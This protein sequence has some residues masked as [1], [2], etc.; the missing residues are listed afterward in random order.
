[1]SK[2]KDDTV[3]E[4]KFIGKH[5]KPEPCIIALLRILTETKIEGVKVDYNGSG[6]S[7]SVDDIFIVKRVGTADDGED[8]WEE[9][10][11][12]LSEELKSAAE[13]TLY[14]IVQ[15]DFNNDGSGGSMVFFVD[16]KGKLNMKGTHQDYY[17][18]SEDTNYDQ[19]LAD[20]KDFL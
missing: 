1:M 4:H 7:G 3:D 2:K 8:D 9:T 11:T 14:H 13:D 5:K 19:V 17:T 10:K 20:S 15:P 12:V 6:D 18:S 16:E